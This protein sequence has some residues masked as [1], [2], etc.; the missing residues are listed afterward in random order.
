[1]SLQR[2]LNSELSPLHSSPLPAS[3]P[4]CPPPL[5]LSALQLAVPR[6]SATEWQER[7]WAPGIPSALS[8]AP[9]RL[10]EAVCSG[11]GRGA[12][13]LPLPPFQRA[14]AVPSWSRTASLLQVSAMI[15]T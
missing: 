5:L 9:Q 6:G 7:N 15:P 4:A 8:A 3:Q 10:K 2:R 13:L 11:G 14:L 1:M 12:L